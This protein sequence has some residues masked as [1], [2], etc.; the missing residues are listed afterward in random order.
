MTEEPGAG[1]ISAKMAKALA[2]PTR[3]RILAELLT[4]PMSPSQFV[5]E[6]GGGLS[7]VSRC[8]RQLREWGYVEVVETRT[9]GQRRGA[10]EHIYRATQVAYFDT[11]AW[12]ALPL[13]LRRDISANVIASYFEQIADAVDAGTFDAEVDRHFS[14]D[15]AMLDRQAWGELGTRLAEVLECL[16]Q[17]AHES[18]RRMATSKEQPIPMTLGLAAFRSPLSC[19]V[20]ELRKRRRRA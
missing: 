16:P 5:D 1:V 13:H 11:P 20:A 9:G 10:V 3:A 7:N 12:E 18:A 17:L 15:R 2:N 8:F 4:R 14:W 19:Q 6:L